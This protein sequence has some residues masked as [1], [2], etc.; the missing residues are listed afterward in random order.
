MI[1][2]NCGKETSPFAQFCG[3]CGSVLP[4]MPTPTETVPKVDTVPPTEVQPPVAAVSP[5][6]DALQ[7]EP[8]AQPMTYQSVAEQFPEE[9]SRYQ[10]YG[11]TDVITQKKSHKKLIIAI[12]AILA[13]IT[14]AVAGFFIYRL[15]KKNTIMSK[16]KEQPTAFLVSAYG[17]TAEA[18]CS[19]DE[20]LSILHS[21]QDRGT[22]TVKM[23][24]GENGTLN[25]T[26]AYDR[27][28]KQLYDKGTLTNGSESKN[29]ELYAD[30]NKI[31]VNTTNG[32]TPVDYYL[33]LKDLRKNA[34]DSPIGPQ[35]P[36]GLGMTQEQ[37]D[38]TM[39]VY[40]YIYNNL[41][42]EDE[43][44]FGLKSLG[45]ALCKDIDEGGKAE[46][47][48]GSTDVFG[49]NAN[50]FI[51]T[52][53]FKDTSV[54]NAVY[55]DLKKWAKE[56]VTINDEINDSVQQALEGIDPIHFTQNLGQTEYDV[57][58][59]HYINKDKSTIMKTEVSVTYQNQ[60]VSLVL[61]FG[62]DPA[63]SNQ[64]GIEIN[65]VGISQKMT[66]TRTSDASTN[67]YVI[68]FSGIFLNGDMT[69]SRDRATGSFTLTQNIKSPYSVTNQEQPEPLTGNIKATADT[70]T[71][72]FDVPMGENQKGRAE[73]IISN[74]AEIKTLTSKNDI[75]E[76]S[77]EEWQ[78]VLQSLTTASM[79]SPVFTTNPAGIIN[80]AET[81]RN[82]AAAASLDQAYKTLY[83][84]VCS[85]VIN[86]KTPQKELNLLDP[87]KLPAPNATVVQ[88]REA[89]NQLTLQ[90]AI[91]YLED[92][93][94]FN[95]DNIGDYG[96]TKDGDINY[97]ANAAN[98]CTP[99]TLDTPLGVIRGSI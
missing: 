27:I 11:M 60:T 47:T 50:A 90:D 33:E 26:T 85:G 13:V 3:I 54:L 36:D 95:K 57:V 20:V 23:D 98:G 12:V 94:F 28:S 8:P 71:V 48:E 81:S 30:L 52:H 70:V 88:C 10:E 5:T 84:G 72:S 45:E 55:L 38:N 68:N 19:Q 53:T 25:K 78:N 41:T 51:V 87:A 2:P 16:I 17:N 34:V 1:C 65:A 37:Y 73:Y 86:T 58:I 59:K 75:L 18:F 67:R 69:Y 49:T 14:L 77:R 29:T 79:L 7:Q 31:V 89:A 44:Y 62:A 6:P 93:S 64:A 61:L 92:S 40:D 21:A 74:K 91:N 24:M 39:D 63:T 82:E 15:I 83:A 35:A 42:R 32:D 96:Y 4:E 80:S 97:L 99:L 46:V 43:N 56:N 22:V 76:A 9:A 66:M